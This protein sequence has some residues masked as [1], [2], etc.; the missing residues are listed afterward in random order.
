[1]ARV[2]GLLVGFAGVVILVWNELN[3]DVGGSI[4]AVPAALLAAFSYGF[5]ANYAKKRLEHVGSVAVA[6]GSLVGAAIF[7]LPGAVWLWPDTPVSQ[8]AWAALIIMAVASTALANVLYFRLIASSGPTTAISVAYLIPIF[9]V[10]FGVAFIDEVVTPNMLAGGAIILLG[11]AL[12]T[13][14]IR[15]KRKSTTG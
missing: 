8:T 4:Y 13:N 2:L 9:A 15:I 12:V 7:L 14:M 1:M 5:A 6:A 11:T 10:I 3:L